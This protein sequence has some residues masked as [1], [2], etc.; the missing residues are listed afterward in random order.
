[1]VM[2]SL[3]KAFYSILPLLSFIAMDFISNEVSSAI[4]FTLNALVSNQPK[5]NLYIQ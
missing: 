1:M 5:R 4:K 3:G 2:V